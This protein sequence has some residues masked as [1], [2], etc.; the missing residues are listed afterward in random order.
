LPSLTRQSGGRYA[1]ENQEETHVFASSIGDAGIPANDHL[2]GHM[3]T[4][5]LSA[6]GSPKS[7]N[8]SEFK[9]HC[10]RVLDDVQATRT[11]VVI[12]KR[13]KPVARLAPIGSARGS[14]RGAWK[15]MVRIRG[16][17]VRVDWS[18]EFEAVR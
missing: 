1:R 16:D 15:G 9:T 7:I 13:G 11:E 12:T 4:C 5:T 18:S 6:V 2:S 8:A 10:L 17:I 3:V 14:L